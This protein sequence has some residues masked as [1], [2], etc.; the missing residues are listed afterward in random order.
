M[1]RSG[2]S[3]TYTQY[4]KELYIAIGEIMPPLKAQ[5]NML[6][7]LNKNL[8]VAVFN[9]NTAHSIP[10]RVAAVETHIKCNKSNQCI[11]PFTGYV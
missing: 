6:K 11:V 9:L 10:V 3:N 2:Y 7:L 1:Q 8:T 5:K 4:G